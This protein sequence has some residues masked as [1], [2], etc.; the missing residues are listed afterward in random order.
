MRLVNAA[1]RMTATESPRRSAGRHAMRFSLQ[2]ITVAMLTFALLFG[3]IAGLLIAA[4]PPVASPP[5]RRDWAQL[6]GSP[7]RNNVSTDTRL[8]VDWNA[9]IDLRSGKWRREEARNIRWVAPLEAGSWPSYL[10]SGP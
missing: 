6:G 3:A 9:G 4:E 1:V 2:A 8:A 7:L 5:A 10:A